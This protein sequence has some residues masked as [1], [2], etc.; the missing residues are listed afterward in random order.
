MRVR[1]KWIIDTNVVVH[2]LLAKH[3]I[4]VCIPRFRLPREFCTVY[5][6]A[7]RPAISFIDRVL[8]LP[9]GAHD[10]VL[11]ELSLSEMF[12]GVRDEVRSMLLFSKGV[13][14]SKWAMRRVTKD[15][16]FPEDLSH[17]VYEATSRG[18]DV[19]LGSDKI[20]IIPSTSPSD[21]EAYL[22][23][24]SS[25][26]FLHPELTTQDA[27]LLAT[28]I[29]QQANLFVTEDRALRRMHQELL[30]AYDLQVVA[31]QTASQSLPQV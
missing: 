8:D 26:V 3:V 10:F 18:L 31:P 4:P 23:V 17:N 12:S 13:P 6:N 11:V 27:I 1:R 15:V 25:L 2:W 20:G 22:E 29:F 19:L 5:E 16:R 21:E 30:Q 14:I 9:G 7:N 24:Y 28:C